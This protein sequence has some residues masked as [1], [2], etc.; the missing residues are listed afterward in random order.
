MNIFLKI[1]I[2]L[3][4]LVIAFSIFGQQNPKDSL[5][6]EWT[7]KTMIYE[8]KL[9]KIINDQF[10]ATTITIKKAK[11]IPTLLKFES[12]GTVTT[13][14][15]DEGYFA[16]SNYT[17]RNYNPLKFISFGYGEISL[18]DISTMRAGIYTVKYSSCNFGGSYKLILINL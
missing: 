8:I 5:V 1:G 15:I 4:S 14:T 3:F 10:E 6:S 18:L 7:N 11:D 13:I 2:L 17:Y 12:G 9:P 16:K